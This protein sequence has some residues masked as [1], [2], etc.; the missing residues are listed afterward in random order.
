MEL[1]TY[2]S[3]L[4]GINISGKKLIKMSDLKTIL[5]EIGLQNVTT[6][7]QSGNIIFQHE[8][9]NN[10]IISEKISKV[11]LDKYGF[12][13]LVVTLNKNELIE[14]NSKNPFLNEDID[15]IH[16]TFL[17]DIPS[18][19]NIEKINLINVEPDKFTIID[20]AIYIFY[21]D[22]YSKTKLVTN[23]FESKLKIKVTDRNIKTVNKLIEI[24]SNL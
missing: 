5:S 1:T 23:F 8:N 12:D 9:I 14:I 16:I 6:Y 19:N 13:V 15:K 4:R 22:K 20:K 3:L 7:I 18:K 21:T 10:S 17:S 11:I 24:S 2:I